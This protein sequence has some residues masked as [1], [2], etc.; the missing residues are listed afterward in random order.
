MQN[1]F[2]AT[3]S[4]TEILAYNN[5]LNITIITENFGITPAYSVYEALD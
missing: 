2:V 4:V 3:D 1:L 5:R